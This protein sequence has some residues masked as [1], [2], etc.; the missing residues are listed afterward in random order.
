ME[1]EML[2]TF[3]WV[4]FSAPPRR[5]ALSPLDGVGE[6][7]SHI[8]SYLK[9]PEQVNWLYFYLRLNTDKSQLL[10]ASVIMKKVG[11]HLNLLKK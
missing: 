8:L 3:V 6:E 10:E 2:G 4:L 5:H 11:S 1:K 9:N 7:F